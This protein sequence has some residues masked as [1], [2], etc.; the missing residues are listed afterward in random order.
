MRLPINRS[1]TMVDNVTTSNH[2]NNQG[3]KNNSYKGKTSHS[4]GSKVQC[5]FCFGPREIYQIQKLLEEHANNHDWY[6]EVKV[7]KST[8]EFVKNRT[9][10]SAHINEVELEA[11][12][13]LM[14]H[15]IKHVIHEINL[16]A[17][18]E[19]EESNKPCM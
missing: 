6:M 15:P 9:G 2:N 8:T 11:L 3:S 12:A 18:S 10:N 19:I 14:D 7:V 1:P 16:F 13:E 17:F 5:K 4:N